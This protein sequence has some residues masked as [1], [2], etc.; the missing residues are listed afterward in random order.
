[1][2][3]ETLVDTGGRK[4]QT[5]VLDGQNQVLRVMGDLVSFIR[6]RGYEP[7]ERLPSERALAERVSVGRGILR[8]ALTCLEAT[9]Y[10]QRRR[11]SGIYL[12]SDSDQLSL[13]AFLLYSK[14]DIPLERRTNMEC[15]EVRKILE[16]HVIQLACE[17]RTEANLSALK[18][19]LNRSQAAIDAGQSMSE[20]DCEFHIALFRAAQNNILVSLVTPF[21]LMSR[22]RRDEFLSDTKRCVESHRQHV[23]IVKAVGD[24][25]IA[26]AIDLMNSHIGRVERH[27]LAS[28][29]NEEGMNAP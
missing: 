22:Q 16:V 24:R 21:Y 8:E 11:N 13:E 3:V 10:L 4:G 5:I 29:T 2:T 7:G 23:A 17:R 1:M 18:L 9:R 20:L 28:P 15:L 14:L 26:K 25:D 12:S 19:I 27:F 6:Q